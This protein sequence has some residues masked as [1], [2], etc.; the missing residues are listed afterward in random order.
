MEIDDAIATLEERVGGTNLRAGRF[1][2]LVAENWKEKTLRSGEG[3]FLDGFD[4]T[5]I[6]PYGDFVFGLARDGAGVAADAFSEI[7]GEPVVGHAG[8]RIYHAT[9]DRAVTTTE[10]RR[11]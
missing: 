3:A 7:D 11:H 6:H 2:A 9:S 4:P 1:V 10:A 8:L 5:A